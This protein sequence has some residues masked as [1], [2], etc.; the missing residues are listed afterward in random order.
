MSLRLFAPAKINLTLRVG[1][2]LPSGRHPLDSLVAFTTHVGDGLE[3]EDSDQLSLDIKGPFGAGLTNDGS[4]LIL[5]AAQLLQLE[6]RTKRGAAVILDKRLPLAS[7]IGG[8]S[9]DAAATLIGLNQLWQVGLSVEALCAVGATLG[10]DVPGCILGKALR[11]TGT[12]ETIEALSQVAN[13]GIV[14][15]NPLV[16]CPTGPVYR[17]FDQ[18]GRAEKLGYEALPDLSTQRELLTFLYATPNDLE[19]AA[20]ALVPE[21]SA[22]LAA[23]RATPKVLL[24]RMSGS[25]ATC[26][27]LY[28]TYEDA[29]HA[30]DCL[31]ANQALDG[32]WV[33]ADEINPIPS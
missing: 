11:M 25:G 24:A 18:S 15:V 32:F 28:P 10:A 26:F 3:L 13:I 20:A 21:I 33:E 29:R 22:V 9:A 31:K 30:R 8:G 6:S 14:L 16:E 23:L 1:P 7:G 17:Q 27:G 5:R 12:G 19:P 4:N 2:P